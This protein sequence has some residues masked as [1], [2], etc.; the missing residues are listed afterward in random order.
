MAVPISHAMAFTLDDEIFLAGGRVGG[1]RSNEVRRFD[2][3]T[4]TFTVVAMLPSN[5]SDASVATSGLTAYLFGGLT[6]NATKQ[7]V[8]IAAS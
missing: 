6:P 4:G 7:I 5:V 8:T 1:G 2:P 3:A